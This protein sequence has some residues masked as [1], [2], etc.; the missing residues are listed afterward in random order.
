MAGLDPFPSTSC[1]E[2]WEQGL[3]FL[4]EFGQCAPLSYGVGVGFDHLIRIREAREQRMRGS[5]AG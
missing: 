5:Q 1:M 4:I 2:L 3:P